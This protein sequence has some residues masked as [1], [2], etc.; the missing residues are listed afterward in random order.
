MSP[1]AAQGTFSIMTRDHHINLCWQYFS[2]CS[3]SDLYLSADHL[4]F[5]IGLFS[6]LTKSLVNVKQQRAQYF[7]RILRITIWLPAVEVE[8]IEQLLNLLRFL[9]LTVCFKRVGE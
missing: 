4:L 6:P 8:V 5:S 1:K 3:S 7:S 2:G 9:N